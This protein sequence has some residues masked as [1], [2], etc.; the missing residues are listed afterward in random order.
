[1]FFFSSCVAKA[2]QEPYI[3]HNVVKGET[4][5]QIA[6]KYQVT[7]FDIFRIN[8]DA[9]NGIQENTILLIPK[10]TSKIKEESKNIIH[11]V[12]A[13]ETLYSIAKEYEVSIDQIKE[14]NEELLKDGLKKGQEIIVGKEKLPLNESYVEVQNTKTATESFSHKVQPKETLFGI[15]TKYGISIEDIIAQNPDVKEGLNEG[16]ILNLKKKSE[17]TIVEINDK[18]KLYTV[19]PKQTLYSLVKEL[20]VSK[21]ELFKLNPELEEGLKEGMIL[22][23]PFQTTSN[24]SIYIEKKIINL[25]DNLNKKQKRDLVLLL[26]FNLNKIQTDST[27]TSKE[28]IKE[29]KFLNLT[30]DFYAG[31]MIAIDSAKVLGLPVTVKILDVQSTRNTS[32]ISQLLKNNDFSNVSAVIGP[33]QN[34]HVETT[35]QLLKTYNTPVISPLSKEVG[36]K[37]PNLY[38]AVPTEEYMIRK[39]FNYFNVNNGNVLGV[40]SP[41]KTSTKTF[42]TENYPQTRIVSYNDKGGVD[43]DNLKSLLVKGKKNFVILESETTAHILNVTNFLKKNKEE[44]NIQLV[45]LQL[46]DTLDFEEIPITNLTELNMLFPSTK[47][48]I[49]SDADKIFEKKY[50]NENG[51]APSTSAARGFDITFDTI[52]R[53]CQE[54]GYANSAEKHKTQY[55]ENSFDYIND[56]GNIINNGVFLLYYDTDY[57]IKQAK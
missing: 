50:R 45:V 4:I 13:K 56:N 2:K 48:E 26:P 17:K 8:P 25:T 30:L 3:K 14:W 21:E 15:A 10:N 36:A 7:P 51:V 35:A 44:Y 34:S 32:N 24:D 31:A 16:D 43:M 52:L 11:E 37:L 55:F 41:K 49:E 28:Y 40:I 42:L 53:I 1:M 18:T 54:E 5:Y 20:K 57:T 9:K 29:D 47:K 33:F 38:N 23:L 12:K 19:K 39:L 46:Y 22:K 6:I 27:K